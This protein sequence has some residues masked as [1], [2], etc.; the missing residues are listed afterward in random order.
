MVDVTYKEV[1]QN[2][3]RLLVGTGECVFKVA[4]GMADALRPIDD[5]RQWPQNYNNGD[6]EKIRPSLNTHGQFRRI[7]VNSGER[8]EQYPRDMIV[9]GNHTWFGAKEEGWTHIAIEYL[10]VDDDE[11]E[12]IAIADNAIAAA[13][14]PDYGQLENLLRRKQQQGRLE[15]TSYTQE[16]LAALAKRNQT[17]TP[18][19]TEEPSVPEDV[20]IEIRCSYDR[21]GW[22][23]E[24]LDAWNAMNGVEVSISG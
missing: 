3:A 15:R 17:G 10:D 11:A 4:P 9:Y 19:G 24:T 13:A 23:R 2:G 12:E 1:V 5:F 22:M 14:R 7:G 8:S 6:V 21:L 20:V 18:K 16:G